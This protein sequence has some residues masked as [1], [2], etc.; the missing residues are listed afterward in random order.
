MINNTLYERMNRIRDLINIPRRQHVLMQNL[1]TWYMLCESMDTIEDTE[2]VLE[3]F[4]KED[5]DSSDAGIGFSSAFNTLDYLVAQ[6]SAVVELYEA[7]VIPYN[8][9]SSLEKIRQ[10]CIE[11]MEEVTD[12]GNAKSINSVDIPELIAI[13]RSILRKSLDNVIKTL[14]KEELYHRKKFDGK[15]LSSAFK[16]ITYPFEKI[17]DAIFS[18]NSPHALLVEAH[19]DQI[20]RSVDE[21]K[22]GL[23]EREEPDDNIS[24]IYENLDYS[25]RHIKVY[26]HNKEE[27]HLHNNKDVYIFAYFARR[28][29]RELEYIAREKDDEY[30]GKYI[31]R[32][33]LS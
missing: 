33:G 12:T 6:Q 17:F 31:S 2:K 30:S 26:F 4:L 1:F 23:K 3:D 7:L 20:L 16:F 11:A 8:K 25:L 21:F 13:Q 29:V 14:T 32:G 24:D 5:V 18:K 27:T 22:A 15:R 10:I 19:V 9:D 28:Q